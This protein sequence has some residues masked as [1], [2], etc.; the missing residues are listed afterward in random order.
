MLNTRN[1]FEI[2]RTK[3][4]VARNSTTRPAEE[5]ANFWQTIANER[6]QFIGTTDP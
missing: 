5:V 1:W 3:I 4:D 2:L 6:G